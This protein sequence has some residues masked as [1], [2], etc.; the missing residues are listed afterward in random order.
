MPNNVLTQLKALRDGVA[1]ELRKDPRYQTLQSLDKSIAEIT[2]VLSSAGLLPPTGQASSLSARL[3][4]LGPSLDSLAEPNTSAQAPKQA[5]I[6]APP[7]AAAAPAQ[8]YA[9]A[10]PAQAYAP[11]AETPKAALTPSPV[12]PAEKPAPVAPPAAPT[13][14]FNEGTV[15]KPQATVPPKKKGI[16]SLLKPAAGIAAVLVAGGV[17][18]EALHLHDQAEAATKAKA[19]ATHDAPKPDDVAEDEGV[20]PPHGKAEDADDNEDEAED[21]ADLAEA[22]EEEAEEKAEHAAED[23]HKPAH[24]HDEHADKAEAEDIEESEDAAV[25]AEEAEDAEDEHPAHAKHG[26]APGKVDHDEAENEDGEDTKADAGEAGG[27]DV[28]PADGKAKPKKSGYTPMAAKAGAAQYAPSIAVKFGKLPNKVDL[29]PLMTPVEDQGQTSSCVANAVAGAYEYWIKKASK[30][31]QNIS[32]LFVYY[33]ARWRDGSQD[34][35]E[36][37]VIQLAMEG[38]QK[39][40]ACA[41]K[42]WPFDPRLILKKPGAEAYKEGAPFRVHDMAQ[43]PLKLDAWKQALAEGKP[44]VFGIALFDSFDECT[45]KGGV[46]PMPAPDAL[47]REKHSGHSMCAVGYSDSEKVFIVRNSWGTDFGDKGY[48]YMPYDYL[49]NPKFND[50]DCWVFVPKVPSQPPRETWL[51]DTTPV[52]NSGKGVDFEIQ[53]YK[54]ADY[55]HIV[56]DLF[57]HARRPWNEHI[58]ADYEHYVS[59]VGKSAFTE[60]ESFD[61]MTF[62]ETTALLAGVGVTAAVLSESFS[63]E[64]TATETTTAETLEESEEDAEEDADDDAE[65]EAEESEDDADDDADEDADDADA[66][67]EDADDADEDAEED[68][69]DAEDDADAE[70]DDAEDDADDADAD[71]EDAEAEDDAEADDEDA[72]SD[73][74]AE[75]EDDADGEDDAEGD[76]DA[77]AEDDAEEDAG[78]DDAEEDAGDDDSGGDDD[79]GGD[80]G[81]GDDE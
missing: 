61:V 67:A 9:P 62:L 68:A 6:A 73:D 18:A 8:A 75:A 60:L 76:D 5:A 77:E 34:K 59:A 22:R 44:I 65:D 58:L 57:Q 70:D 41:E 66:D 36:G 19:A 72:E 14:G 45:K 24:G 20:E 25:K 38:L 10:A 17:A 53:P 49:L 29:R 63:S 7:M 54:V 79:G 28:A 81:G 23:H 78:D 1:E 47:A 40:G 50:A 27:D 56:I 16:S 4:G 71:G 33:N 42:A 43:V 13:P 35:D 32:R 3:S 21:E 12:A 39:F 51:D 15:S 2:T 11:V 30:Q 52:T 31:D 64:M 74:D 26:R 46:V 55:E 48:C 69:D 37:S 80:D